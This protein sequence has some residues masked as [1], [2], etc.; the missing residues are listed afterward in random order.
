M[1]KWGFQLFV[2]NCGICACDHSK[3]HGLKL[4]LASAVT[5]TIPLSCILKG[6]YSHRWTFTQWPV[7]NPR[8]ASWYAG[9]PKL[10]PM[11]KNQIE[12]SYSKGISW[13]KVSKFWPRPSSVN[14][15]CQQCTETSLNVIRLLIWEI[16]CGHILFPIQ[17]TRNS[18]S[19]TKSAAPAA[20]TIQNRWRSDFSLQ[21]TRN[22]TEDAVACDCKWYAKRLC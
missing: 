10:D 3:S 14:E 5:W 2:T 15:A 18:F 11:V 6:D 21:P 1:E 13:R 4:K 22:A 19:H 17:S 16:R 8:S 20:T 9:I 7:T 12:K